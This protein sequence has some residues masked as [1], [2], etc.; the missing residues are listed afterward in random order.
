M[1]TEDAWVA[2]TELYYMIWYLVDNGLYHQQAEFYVAPGGSTRNSVVRTQEE[3][4]PYQTYRALNYSVA[5]AMPNQEAERRRNLF[6][7]GT[8]QR[9]HTVHSRHFEKRSDRGIML[10]NL[11]PTQADIY[12][13]I[14]I[15]FLRLY[16]DLTNKNDA[17]EK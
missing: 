11:Y 2:E 6:D 12:V 8:I 16:I 13:P 10:I 17:K 5:N 3:Q 7:K 15:S 14:I 1:A 4:G 9:S